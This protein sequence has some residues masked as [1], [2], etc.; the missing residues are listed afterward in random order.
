MTEGETAAVWDGD[1]VDVPDAVRE[2]GDGVGVI[3]EDSDG[4]AVADDGATKSVTYTFP[5]G[6]EPS[7]VYPAPTVALPSKDVS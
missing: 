4:V 2:T 1:G 6:A 7:C 5:A 3:V